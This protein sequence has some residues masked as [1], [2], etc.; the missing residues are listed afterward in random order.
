M[1]RKKNIVIKEP[2]RSLILPKDNNFILKMARK[3]TFDV[4]LTPIQEEDGLF[5]Q[6]SAASL[7][8]NRNSEDAETQTE[9]LNA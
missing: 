5:K 7:M 1:E 9:L 2:K 3:A 8:Q 4:S 6:G